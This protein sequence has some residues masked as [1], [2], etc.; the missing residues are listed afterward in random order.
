MFSVICWLCWMFQDV[1]NS[2]MLSS[3][4]PDKVPHNGNSN[5]IHRDISQYCDEILRSHINFK[6]CKLYITATNKIY[7]I[8]QSVFVVVNVPANSLLIWMDKLFCSLTLRTKKG[9]MVYQKSVDS[10]PST[11]ARSAQFTVFCVVMLFR[12]TWN[13]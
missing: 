6:L 5:R 8:L 1:T 2:N 12:P 9:V 11:R 13:E 3:A 4:L 7:N 10:E